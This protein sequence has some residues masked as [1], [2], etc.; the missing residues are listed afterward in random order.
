MKAGAAR[1][2]GEQSA[3]G[4][5]FNPHRPM[6]AGAAGFRAGPPGKGEPFQSSPADEGRCCQATRYIKHIAK[7]SIL[8]G[9]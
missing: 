2:C 6:K 7:V 4:A 5:C 3:E 9:R 8:T 1:G